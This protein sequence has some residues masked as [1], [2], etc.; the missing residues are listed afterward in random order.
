[1]EFL[2]RFQSIYNICFESG[3]KIIVRF[4]WKCPLLIQAQLSIVIVPA[5]KSYLGI[6][7]QWWNKTQEFTLQTFH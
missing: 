6:E 7:P 1:M 4:F 5:F 3:T 2:Y